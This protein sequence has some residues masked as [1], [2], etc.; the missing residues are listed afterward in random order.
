MDLLKWNFFGHIWQPKGSLITSSNSLLFFI[1][2]SIKRSWLQNKNEYNFHKFFWEPTFYITHFQKHF[3]HGLFV[4]GSLAK[5]SE[6]SFWCTFSACFL[7]YK[8]CLLNC[9]SI[10]QVSIPDLLYFS[11]CFLIL[12]M[13]TSQISRFILVIFCNGWQWRKE[14][15]L[16]LQKYEYLENEKTFLDQMK[17]IIHDF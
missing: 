15:Q 5:R 10:D 1:T 11:L 9:V 3:F 2:M 8:Y 13:M 17:T 6:T 7:P 4:L 16:C 12:E 14:D